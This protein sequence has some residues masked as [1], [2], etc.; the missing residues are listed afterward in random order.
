[1]RIILLAPLLFISFVGCI[2][3]QYESATGVV[4]VELDNP[5]RDTLYYSEIVDSV[6]YID[7]ESS[8]EAMIGK[9]ADLDYNG[10]E[11]VALDDKTGLVKLFG[12]DGHFISQIGA[13]GHGP[14]EYVR[15]QNIDLDDS[16][17]A[18]F[19][20]VRSKVIRYSFDGTSLSE[21]SIGTAEDFVRIS[22]GG[23]ETYLV[24]DYYP[25]P[26]QVGGLYLVSPAE[27]VKKELWQRKKP[28]DQN[29]LWEIFKGDGEIAIM[30]PQY[31]FTLLRSVNDS[32]EVMYELNVSP[33]L[34]DDELKRIID[35]DFETFIS[36]YYR[37]IFFNSSRWS[38]I[39]FANK[40]N[41]RCLLIDKKLNK[42]SLAPGFVND[43]D[44]E[45]MQGYAPVLI[46]GAMVEYVDGPDEDSN[47]RLK[48]YHLKK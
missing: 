33:K 34:T 12:K 43:F 35:R 10:S 18:V 3:G 17:V 42:V 7:L 48:L 31:E 27:N 6:T 15:V 32:V 41:F 22:P 11:I 16:T 46:D 45:E 38:I 5:D 4:D 40:D 24:A 29:H 30:S 19:D 23:K 2:S 25:L 9:I 21:D 39:S 13:R 44:K 28:V 20:P 8:D 47:P 1:M 26:K 37:A 14:N 36:H